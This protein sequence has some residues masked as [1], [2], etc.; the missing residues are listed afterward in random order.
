MIISEE[1]AQSRIRRLKRKTMRKKRA[2]LIRKRIKRVKRFGG[3]A[4]TNPISRL[5]TIGRRI[6]SWPRESEI[7]DDNLYKFVRT[8]KCVDLTKVF[9]KKSSQEKGEKEEKKGI[10]NIIVSGGNCVKHL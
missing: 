3:Y 2:L 5:R 9:S 4:E 8:K 1:S 10:K 7:L 6:P